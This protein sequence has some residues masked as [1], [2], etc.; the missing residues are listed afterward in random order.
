MEDEAQKFL[1]CNDEFLD[2]NEYLNW[3]SKKQMPIE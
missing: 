2:R 3:A 1:E